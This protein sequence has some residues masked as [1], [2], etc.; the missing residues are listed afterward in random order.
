MKAHYE[1]LPANKYYGK[2]A[3]GKVLLKNGIVE[4]HG[5]SKEVEAVYGRCTKNHENYKKLG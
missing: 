4:F 3:T 1:I 2:H 5:T